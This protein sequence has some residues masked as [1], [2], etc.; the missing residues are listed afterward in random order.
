MGDEYMP[1]RTGVDAADDDG[2]GTPPSELEEKRSN[3]SLSFWLAVVLS[4]FSMASAL[5]LS[6]SLN[7]NAPMNFAD[8]QNLATLKRLTA[9]PN[10]NTTDHIR[11]TKRMPKLWFPGSMI[12]ANAAQPDEFYT[13]SK[14][15]TLS[16]TDSMFYRWKLKGRDSG[17]CYIWAV[18]PE[19][20]T[21]A[22]GGKSYYSEGDVTEIEI[23]NVTPSIHKPTSF[24]WNT[25]PLRQNLLGTVNFTTQPIPHTGMDGYDGKELKPPTPRLPCAGE[26]TITLEIACKSCKLE[27]DQ[28][29]SD[30]ALGFDMQELS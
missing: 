21:L 2:F 20:S 6:A 10:M 5:A 1:L 13:P 19:R 7:A 17:K 4:V 14:S 12:R 18:V 28:V 26:T 29:F 30:P 15:V 24:S 23:W 11:T 22:K 27:F 16:P 3:S 9:Y 8:P 25:R